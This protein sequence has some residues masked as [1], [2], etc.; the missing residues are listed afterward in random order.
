[1][2]QILCRILHCSCHFPSFSLLHHCLL[3]LQ[4]IPYP[5]LSQTTPCLPLPYH[6]L[7]L[8]SINHPLEWKE[9]RMGESGRVRKGGRM[10]NGK[11]EM[12]EVRQDGRH[13]HLIILYSFSFINDLLNMVLVPKDVLS[14]PGQRISLQYHWGCHSLFCRSLDNS[15]LRWILRQELAGTHRPDTWLPFSEISGK[16]HLCPVMVLQRRS[17]APGCRPS[18]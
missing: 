1:M 15:T 16:F 4:N 2:W 10:E 14:S 17:S 3:L 18:T 9:W 6:H 7:N 13:L 5:F 11:D 12:G 8:P